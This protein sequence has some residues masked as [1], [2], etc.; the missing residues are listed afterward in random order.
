MDQSILELVKNAYDADAKNCKIELH[1]ETEPGG[2]IVV[3]DDGDGMSPDQIINGWLVLGRS[4][5][6]SGRLT[7]L[8]RHPAGNK[9]LGRLAAL[10]LGTSVELTS[11][12]RSKKQ[13]QNKLSIDWTMFENASLVEDVALEIVSKK[14]GPNVRGTSIRLRNL[15]NSIAAGDVRRLARSLVLLTDPFSDGKQGFNIELVSAEFAETAALVKRK[16]FDVADYHLQSW[17]D[18]GGNA[19]AKILDWQGNVMAEAGLGALGRGAN[20]AKYK[21]PKLQFDLWVFL[22]GGE[23]PNFVAAKVSKTEIRS[24]LAAF[25][26]VHIYDRGIRVA[27]YGNP[28]DDWLEMNLSR[29]KSPEERPGTNTSIGR[30][31]IQESAKYSLTQKTDRSGFIEDGTFQEIRRFARDS[32]EWLAKWRLR[33]AELRRE[34][35]VKLA[36]KAT[37]RQRERV[38]AAIA[39]APKSIASNVLAAFEG[40]ERRRDKESELLRKELQLYRTLSTAGITAATFAHESQGNPI[41]LIEMGVTALQARIPLLVKDPGRAKLLAPVRDIGLAV[42][43]LS[44]LTRATL[45]LVSTSKRKVGRVHLHRVITRVDAMFAPFLKGRGAEMVVKFGKGDPFLRGSEAA[46]ESILTNLVNNSLKSFE[47]AGTNRRV[48]F[49][50]TTT[51]ESQAQL[52]VSDTGPGIRDLELEE[53]WLPGVT[54]NPEGTGLGL[55]IIRDTVRDLGGRA[56]VEASGEHG[57]ARFQI[58]LPILGR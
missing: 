13:I 52:I 51:T 7:R 29:V 36:P 9:G 54:T 33:Q 6:E 19:F 42:E 35:E 44:F 40:Y 30:M 4:G 39:A 14:V 25:G 22:L 58:S 41:K 23:S 2:E 12:S 5:K 49:V 32:L 24:W 48:V 53:I 11:V 8:G 16:Y 31:T 3:T 20:P 10:R 34:A 50:E 26:G 21:A 56:S 45:S 28:G 15:R 37:M 43:S 1:N 18:G 17:I 55:T 57:G 47:L 38:E 46:V 27:P